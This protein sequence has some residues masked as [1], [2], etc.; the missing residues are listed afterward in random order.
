MNQALQVYYLENGKFTDEIDKLGI[1]IKTKTENYKYKIEKKSDINF[2][3]H[4]TAQKETLKSYAGV[5][6]VQQQ[7]NEAT[8]QTILCESDSGTQ[9]TAQDSDTKDAQLECPDGFSELNQSSQPDNSPTSN[10][11]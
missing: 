5:V 4:A 7:G 8:T 10:T 6:V 1:G 3:N 9:G 11:P 2:V